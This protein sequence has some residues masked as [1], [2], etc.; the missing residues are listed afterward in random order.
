MK[1]P[2][3]AFFSAEDA[4]SEGVEGKFYL[5][6]KEEIFNILDTNE[7]EFISKVF[8]VKEEGN[9]N[10]EYSRH[11]N[12]NILHMKQDIDELKDMLG[13]EANEIEDK[14]ESVRLKLFNEREKRVHPHKDDKI[15][16][17]WNGL[18]IASLSKSSQ[19]FKEKKYSDSAKEAADFILENLCSNGRLM[20]RY[21][22]EEAGVTAN[23]DDY[24]FFIW[25][26]L[27]LYTAVFDIKY[28][29]AAIE[30]NETLLEHFWDEVDG[31][32]YFTA[33]DAEEV[34]M[35]EKKTYDSATP[36]GNSVE[37][38][39]LIRIARITEDPEI[40]AKAVKMESTFSEN[41]KRA[42]TAHTQFITAVDF[43]V[44]PII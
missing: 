2:D 38:L 28:L 3:G 37:I 8:N 17:D 6:T 13:L 27:E 36:S 34:L 10:D 9:F 1:S 23:L 16:T 19:V 26:L 4:D 32:F 40:E 44:G 25:G 5:W 20:H 42:P 15:L 7:G 33:D 39:N 22:D 30:L 18:M 29:K 43:K 35:R 14:I 11:S 12:Q 24:S 21:R 41:I 31:G